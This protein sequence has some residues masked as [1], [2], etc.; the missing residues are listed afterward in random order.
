MV[1]AQGERSAKR[2]RWI[3]NAVLAAGL[4]GAIALAVLAIGDPATATSSATRTATATT[5]DVAATVSASGNV[6]ASDSVGVNFQGSGGTVNAIYVKVGDE[7]HKG[8]ALAKVDDTSARQALES[9]QAGLASAQA[10]YEVTTQGQ[11]TAEQA[12][13]QASVDAAEVSLQNARTSL[14]HA[15]Q[16]YDLDKQQQDALVETATQAYQQAT[17]P[18]VK[19]QALNDLNQAKQTRASTLLRDRQ[20]VQDAQGQ[21]SAAEVQLQSARAAAAVGAQSATP[22]EI[23]QAQAQVT[24]AQVQVDQAR[25]TLAQTTL[26]APVASTVTS[27]SGTVGEDSSS[28]TGSTSSSTTGASSSS[29]TAS[30]F[31]V[32]Q[33]ITHLQ[34]T[35]MVAEAD[36]AKVQVGDTATVTFSA[37]DESARGRVTSIDLQDTVS[38]N[39]VRYGVTVTLSDT[40][41][42]VRLG[43][44][45][46][47]S[48]VTGVARN[49]LTVP[50]SAVTSVGNNST[51]TVLQNGQQSVR[52]VQVGLVG[53]SSTEI[54]SGLSEGDVVVL[55][56]GTGSSGLT[57]PGGDIPGGFGGGLG[58]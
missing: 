13:S 51:V 23:A 32:I 27:I 11:T 49:V 16:T 54:T 48:I 31:V 22:G 50:S 55:T 46:S 17:D 15:Q 25:V 56:T 53:D 8:Q 57:F 42:K 43:Q 24:S 5:G 26:R 45:A 33:G 9:A 14:A 39:V 40:P 28:A 18:T 30:G 38:N 12:S 4:A 1:M 10:Q 7:V 29:T 19:A 20:Q 3:V 21:V 6:S 37:L 44:T 58:G 52:P 47:V 2:R 35:S 36:A 41:R 34:V